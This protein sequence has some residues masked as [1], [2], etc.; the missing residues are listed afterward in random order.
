MNKTKLAR[1]ID[2]TL[3]DAGFQKAVV[4]G[5]G[6]KG[7]GTRYLRNGFVLDTK[8]DKCVIVRYHDWDTTVFMLKHQEGMTGYGKTALEKSLNRVRESL[9]RYKST[10]SSFHVEDRTTE[11]GL[12]YL[13]IS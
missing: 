7:R 5:L 3:K 9:S 2:H 13:E 4:K 6:W 11:Y 12:P 1:E 10:L 8:Q